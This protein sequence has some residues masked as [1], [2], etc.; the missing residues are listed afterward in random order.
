MA[1]VDRDNPHKEVRFAGDSP[2][3]EDGF[4]PS[5]PVRGF[6]SHATRQPDFCTPTAAAH[7]ATLRLWRSA[8]SASEI[9]PDSNLLGF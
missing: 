5:V 4:E 8:M 7:S 3:E 9:R 6:R 1:L 2:V